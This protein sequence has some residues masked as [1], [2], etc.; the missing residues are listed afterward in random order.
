MYELPNEVEYFT[1]DYTATIAHF[2]CLIRRNY[3]SFHGKTSFEAKDHVEGHRFD[4]VRIT[5]LPR[6]P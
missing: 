4:R 5:S 3:I 2:A 6:S 1:L